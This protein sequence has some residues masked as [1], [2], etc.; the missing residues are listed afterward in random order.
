MIIYSTSASDTNDGGVGARACIVEGLSP[1]LADFQQ[2]L[3]L[4]N[5]TTPVVLAKSYSRIFRIRVMDTGD[6]LRNTGNVGDIHLAN[7]ADTILF[8]HITDSGRSPSQTQMALWTL[9]YG[10]TGYYANTSCS[11]NN[12][13]LTSVYVYSRPSLEAFPG[14]NPPFQN[15]AEI[16]SKDGIYDKDLTVWEQVPGGTDI[17]VRGDTAD[18]SGTDNVAAQ[19]Y[20]IYSK[21]TP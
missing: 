10:Y 20:V 2:E 6:P 16:K 4:L 5:G 15:K 12:S 18:Q 8:G 1:D 21:D 17:E 11:T 13:K 7:L 19:F 3:V 14:V 9:P